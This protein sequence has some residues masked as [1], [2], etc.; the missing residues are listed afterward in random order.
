MNIDGSLPVHVHFEN[1]SDFC[2]IY[3]VNDVFVVTAVSCLRDGLAF[4]HYHSFM[5]D[6]G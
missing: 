3:V 2:L 1:V 6:V 4:G 5:V